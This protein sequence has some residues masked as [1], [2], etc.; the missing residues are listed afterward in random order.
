MIVCKGTMHLSTLNTVA[1]PGAGLGSSFRQM[2][3]L[4]DVVLCFGWGVWMC[5]GELGIPM[6]AESESMPKTVEKA[7]RIWYEHN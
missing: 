3:F 7:H 4:Q 1:L 5:P 6:C 2:Q